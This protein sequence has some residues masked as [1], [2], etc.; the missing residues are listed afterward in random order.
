VAAN[1][2]PLTLML[3]TVAIGSAGRLVALTLDRPRTIIAAAGLEF[4]AFWAVGV[5]LALRAGS[6][7]ACIAALS[8]S[9]LFA[10]Y[11]TVRVRPELPYS[12]T[13]AWRAV[14]ASLVFVPLAVLRVPWPANA[15]LFVAGTAVYH[16]LL[17]RLGVITASEMAE[18]RRLLGN[19][20]PAAPSRS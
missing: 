4:V 6:L 1:L 14:I 2:V 20:R 7:G 10:G 8:A 3:V 13:P 19:G 11:L 12:L 18:F 5:P 15:A 17:R 16:A 9:A